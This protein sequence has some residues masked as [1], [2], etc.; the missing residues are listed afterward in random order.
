MREGRYRS[1]ITGPGTQE[2]LR[3]LNTLCKNIR[4]GKRLIP[5]VNKYLYSMSHLPSTVLGIRETGLNKWIK[6]Q[7]M[8]Q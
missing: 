2:E 8:F 3:F 4:G 6:L 1:K 5:L 7:L